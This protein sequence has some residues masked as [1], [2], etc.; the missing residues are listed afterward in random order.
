MRLPCD[1]SINNGALLCAGATK[2][3][4]RRLNAF[5]S[6]EVG[7]ERYVIELLQK[8]L[9]KPMTERVWIDHGR[10]QFV[11]DR[12]FLQLHCDAARRDSCAALVCKDKARV[13][14]VFQ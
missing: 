6:H 7:K 12:E 13:L 10:V 11:F 8:V 3:N 1:N 9:G 14:F 2:V 4:A 5:M